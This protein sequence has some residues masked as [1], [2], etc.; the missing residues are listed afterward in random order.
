MHINGVPF[1]EKTIYA[2]RVPRA[3]TWLT[4]YRPRSMLMLQTVNPNIFRRTHIFEICEKQ[5][6]VIAEEALTHAFV[7]NSSDI[8]A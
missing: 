5:P 3:E 8:E 6:Q 1:F 2:R 4:V 7:G